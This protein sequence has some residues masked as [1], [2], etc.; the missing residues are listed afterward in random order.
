MRCPGCGIE[1][2]HSALR[3]KRCGSCGY[4]LPVVGSKAG[5]TK[6]QKVAQIVSEG[7]L[8]LPPPKRKPVNIAGKNV[9]NPDEEY[10]E[11]VVHTTDIEDQPYISEEPSITTEEPEFT[12]PAQ[13]RTPSQKV[14][15]PRRIRDA[16]EKT[17]KVE[18]L[19]PPPP[20]NVIYTPMPEKKAF[21]QDMALVVFIIISSLTITAL[22]IVYMKT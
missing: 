11:G 18:V 5:Q 21:W 22:L 1:L 2:N 7:G 9:G 13:I 17:L 3:R 8:K 20:Q 6:S 10:R 15:K 19:P 4:I 14:R 12:V 16:S